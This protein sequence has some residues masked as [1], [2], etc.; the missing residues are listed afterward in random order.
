MAEGIENKIEM[1]IKS[2][3]SVNEGKTTTGIYIE[4]SDWNINSN[5]ELIVTNDGRESTTKNIDTGTTNFDDNDEDCPFCRRCCK[6]FITLLLLLFVVLCIIIFSEF[7]FMNKGILL[8]YQ[9]IKIL[10]KFLILAGIVIIYILYIMNAFW[11]SNTH[12]YLNGKELVTDIIQYVDHMKKTKPCI[13]FHCECYHM[14]TTTST[15]T[16]SDGNSYTD[17]YTQKVT[18]YREKEKFLFTSWIDVSPTLRIAS[19]I[20]KMKFVKVFILGDKTT[21]S[22]YY[23]R[24]K[25]FNDRNRNRDEC[26]DSWVSLDIPGFKGTFIW[27]FLFRMFI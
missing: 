6:W 17:S 22:L 4:G 10:L 13:S 21:K 2:N 19:N 11:C 5:Q 15:S 8:S 27:M 14:E 20:A 12:K 9:S 16:D 7:E 18:T 23:Y 25:S 24:K 1:E 26:Y 3:E